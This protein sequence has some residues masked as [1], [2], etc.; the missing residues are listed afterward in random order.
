VISKPN[1]KSVASN[2]IMFNGT[3]SIGNRK[4]LSCIHVR[5]ISGATACQNLTIT[6]AINR[7]APENKLNETMD[8]KLRI[9]ARFCIDLYFEIMCVFK[10]IV[11]TWASK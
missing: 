11:A 3:I 5:K 4:K 1:A 9:L 8:S 7:K 2:E 6:N 10:D